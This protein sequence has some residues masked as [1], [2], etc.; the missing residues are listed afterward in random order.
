M[1]A[2]HARSTAVLPV[3][4]VTSVNKM[5]AWEEIQGNVEDVVK[6]ASAKKIKAAAFQ[7]TF[8]DVSA[9]SEVTRGIAQ[10]YEKVRII[11]R[12][13]FDYLLIQLV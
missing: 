12:P 5:S 2:K 4:S 11:S 13:N 9:C 1:S 6:D 8:T 7:P 3:R 10:D